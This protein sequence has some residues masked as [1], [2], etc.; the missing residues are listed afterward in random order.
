MFTIILCLANKFN[1]NIY[2]SLSLKYCIIIN[3][4]QNDVVGLL[5]NFLQDQDSLMNSKVL[6]YLHSFISIWTKQCWILCC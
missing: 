3:S 1:Y 6:E 4:Y 5:K 2:V